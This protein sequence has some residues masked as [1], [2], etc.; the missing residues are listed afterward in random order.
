LCIW[1]RSNNCIV[2]AAAVA[3]AVTLVVVVD[4]ANVVLAPLSLVSASEL[5]TKAG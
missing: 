1:P 4:G 3:V 5:V 2:V